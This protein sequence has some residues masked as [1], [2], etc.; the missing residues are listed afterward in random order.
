MD[1][2][3]KWAAFTGIAPEC[4]SPGAASGAPGPV[5]ILRDDWRGALFGDDYSAIA[6]TVDP[7]L[8][9]GGVIVFVTALG[10]HEVRVFSRL[11]PGCY[12]DFAWRFDAAQ[13]DG[14][15]SR[16]NGGREMIGDLNNRAISVAR[17]NNGIESGRANVVWLINPRQVSIP[18]RP[19]E[20]NLRIFSADIDETIDLNLASLAVRHQESAG[21]QQLRILPWRRLLV[22]MN[23]LRDVDRAAFNKIPAPLKSFVG[24]R[25]ASAQ[26]ER[27]PMAAFADW[28]RQGLLPRELALIIPDDVAPLRDSIRL[29]QRLAAQPDFLKMFNQTCPIPTL[30]LRVDAGALD[31]ADLQVFMTI[32]ALRELHGFLEIEM[33]KLV[34]RRPDIQAIL[35]SPQGARQLELDEEIRALKVHPE[36]VREQQD[37]QDVMLRKSGQYGPTPRDMLRFQ[38]SQLAMMQAQTIGM[39]D[40]LM[41]IA[42]A[43]DANRKAKASTSGPPWKVYTPYLC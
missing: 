22:W 6:T 39:V 19:D 34:M 32:G 42:A 26:I 4:W 17:L 1:S 23:R 15:N 13:V 5:W 30:L 3:Q 8:G 16:P 11:R 7:N 10:I 36:A 20:M 37:A 18:V 27:L 31:P 28:S 12:Y 2:E 41:G 24:A 25:D 35:K 29:Q 14:D 21:E 43:W 38:E 40:P 9:P 33:N